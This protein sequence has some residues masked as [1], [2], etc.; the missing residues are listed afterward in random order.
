MHDDKGNVW[1]EDNYDGY[2]EFGG[3]DFYE[4]VSDQTVRTS[5][6][7]GCPLRFCPPPCCG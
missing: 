4:L 7:T 2:C 5:N 6:R 3:K 1:K